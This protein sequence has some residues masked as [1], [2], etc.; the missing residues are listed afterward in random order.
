MTAPDPVEIIIAAG[1]ADLPYDKIDTLLQRLIPGIT[2][3]EMGDAYIEAGQRMR[4]EGEA[5]RQLA[6]E[7]DQIA[8]EMGI[9]TH[10]KTPIGTVLQIAADRGN[11]RAADIL[12]SLRR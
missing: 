7:V 10:P 5:L 3:A 12:N 6:D 2:T 1:D 4:R 11:E 8:A 9:A